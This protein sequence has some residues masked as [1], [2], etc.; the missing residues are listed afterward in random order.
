MGR[1]KSIMT[2]ARGAFITRRL[3]IRREAARRTLEANAPLWRTL[4]DYL[5][6]ST[7]TGGEYCDYLALY[8]HVR[9]YRPSEILECGT[10]V[11]TVVLAHALMENERDYGIRG[12]IT[13]MEDKEKW[14]RVAQDLLPRTLSPY[15]DLVLSPRVEDGWYL[16]RGVRY[17]FLPDR[18]YDFVFVDGP[19]FDSPSDGTLTFDCDLIRVVE[20]AEQPV[21]AIIDDRLSTS[22]VCQKVFGKDKARY[23]TRDRL[24]FVGPVTRDHLRGMDAQKPCFIHSFRYFGNTDLE[25]CMQPRKNI[26]GSK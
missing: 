19:D 3:H 26:I 4:T 16:F 15:V 8:N 10:G 11:S 13:S 24:C 23:C 9:N 20:K 17:K 22:F 21:W 2:A 18:P 1:I 12:R 5:A 25:I 7:S 6:K 14:H